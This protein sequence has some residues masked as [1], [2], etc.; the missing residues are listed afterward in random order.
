MP[1]AR[2]EY[3]IEQFEEALQKFAHSLPKFL[4]VRTDEWEL[5]F[6]YRDGEIRRIRVVSKKKLSEDEDGFI[7][8]NWTVFSI[9]PKLYSDSDHS[10]KITFDSYVSQEE[11]LGVV[12]GLMGGIEPKSRFSADEY[13]K[14][15]PNAKALK[16]EG[17]R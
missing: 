11:V 2:C 9:E 17:E 7:R 4:T 1:T 3:T 15:K 14:Q 6:S 16:A 12:Q 5:S 10:T 8:W 13:I